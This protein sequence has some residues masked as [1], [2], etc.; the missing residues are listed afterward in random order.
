MYGKFERAEIGFEENSVGP[1]ELE[2]VRE[3]PTEPKV[4]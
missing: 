4:C 1:N 3:T 2:D